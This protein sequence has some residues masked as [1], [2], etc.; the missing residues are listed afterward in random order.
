MITRRKA[1]L[2]ALQELD[3]GM[4]RTGRVD[5]P[6]VL[7]ELTGMTIRF[8][9]TLHRGQGRFGV[10]LASAEPLEADLQQLPRSGTARG[11]IVARWN[12]LSVVA[13]HLSE[14]RAPGWDKHEPWLGPPPSRPAPRWSWAI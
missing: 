8:F 3:Q 10:A 5:Q 2:V 11:A 12:G 7:E 6:Q 1:P 4:D 9:P 13:T 14:K